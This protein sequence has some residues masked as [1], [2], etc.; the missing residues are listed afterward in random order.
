M[1]ADSRRRA[2]Q[3]SAGFSLVEI[4]IA[5]FVLALM[6]MGLIP[7]MISAMKLSVGNR[8]QV[9]ATAFANAQVSEIQAAFSN[10]TP[11]K[12]SELAGFEHTNLADPG[13]TGLVATRRSLTP[14]GSDPFA[15]ATVRVSVADADEP[16]KA[17][18][19]LTTEVLVT[20]G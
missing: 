5:M 2:E 11:R 18:V 9:A 10:D 16:G 8:S 17:L 20:Q 13:G 4:V 12:C 15:T 14:C 6:A 19:T 7:L 1:S 3:A